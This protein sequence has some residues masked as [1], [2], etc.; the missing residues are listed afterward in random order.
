LCS[1]MKLKMVCRCKFWS[2]W[3]SHY[4]QL[5]GC[6]PRIIIVVGLQLHTCQVSRFCREFHGFGNEMTVSR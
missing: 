5:V 3:Y 2:F 1:D 4:C 6:D